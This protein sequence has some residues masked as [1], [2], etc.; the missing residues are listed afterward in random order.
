VAVLNGSGTL[1]NEVVA[2]TL[3]AG[4]NPGNGLLLVNGEFGSRL[5]R[6]ARRFGLQ[7][8]ILSWAWGKPW[9]LDEIDIALS[10]EPPG[11]WVWGVHLESSTGVLNDLPG[12]VALARRRGIRVCADCISS[13]GAVPLDLSEVYLATGASGKSLG[14]YAGAAIIFADARRLAGLDLGRVPSY[15]DL[16]AALATVGT[17]YTFPSPTLVALDAALDSYRAPEQASARYAHYQEL[18]AYI[19]A[20]I[21][22]LGLEPL[23][24]EEHAAPVVT[25]F[26]PAGDEKAEDF[27]ARCQRWGFE[28][29][30]QSGYLAER[31]L[32]QIATMGAVTR[33]ICAPLFQQLENSLLSCSALMT[34]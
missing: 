7:P 12:L 13:L 5:A 8:R 1:A 32:V 33:E 23:A 29:G 20:E 11:S 26:A 19:R 10:Q 28:L 30:G 4:P 16:P 27:V 17:R 15:L 14:A 2:A 3:T 6:Q 9:D 22:R 34:V 31:R 21:R 25:T 18:G 24:P